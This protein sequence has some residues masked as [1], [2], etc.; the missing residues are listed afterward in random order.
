MSSELAKDET[1]QEEVVIGT[2][3]FPYR[4]LSDPDPDDPDSANKVV[5]R[6]ALES[7]EILLTCNGGL[8]V[9]VP[10]KEPAISGK[11]EVEAQTE[12]AETAVRLF[13]RIICELA[14]MGFIS[15]PATLAQLGEARLHDDRIRMKAVRGGREFYTERTLGPGQLL[16]ENWERFGLAHKLVPPE[17][18]EIVVG[19][20]A[21]EA[22]AQISETLPALVAGAYFMFSRQQIAEAVVDSW[23]VNEQI[24]D[25]I[26]QD[27]VKGLREKARRKRL[28]DTRVYTSAVRIEVLQTVGSLP[29]GLAQELQVARKVRNDLAHRARLTRDDA[30]TAVTAMKHMVEKFLGRP[31]AYVDANQAV[32]L[33]FWSR[34]RKLS[35]P[36]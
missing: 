23:T 14:L 19:H 12:F 30:S 8:F 20:A 24:L 3:L 33:F 10:D 7:H 17:V 29:D 4:R 32:S 6:V 26:W 27:Y 21:T 16:R 9:R 2:Y 13:N 34:A 25:A 35:V 5:R 18:L 1:V 11:D 28:K 36:T 15:E 31:I 22:L